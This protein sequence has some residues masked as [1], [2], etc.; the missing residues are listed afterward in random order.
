MKLTFCGA[1]ETVTGS[2]HLLELEDGFK[3]LLDCGLYQGRE[4]DME[5]FNRTWL[6]EPTEL[7]CV[8]LS[9]AHI[10]HSGRLP[11]LVKDGFTGPI[12]ST[13]AT[14]SL[15]SIMLLDSAVIQERDAE[16]ENKKLK[17]KKKKFKPVEP[18]TY[19][20]MQRKR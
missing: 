5:S 20:M 1:A 11:K 18:Y 6:F 17:K 9:H 19:L 2:A 16:W 12:Y 3:I 15:A 8:V 4:K 14:R 7:D 10:D 13:H